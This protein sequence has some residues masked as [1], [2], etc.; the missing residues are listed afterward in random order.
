MC[1]RLSP[2]HPATRVVA[3]LYILLATFLIGFFTVQ[4]ISWLDQSYPSSV[5]NLVK[6]VEPSTPEGMRDPIIQQTWPLYIEYE[7]SVTSGHHVNAVFRLTNV[8]S[9]TAYFKLDRKTGKLPSHLSNAF[10]WS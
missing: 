10:P 6:P 8:N 2:S 5:E 1:C 7:C 9:E 4:A 3:G